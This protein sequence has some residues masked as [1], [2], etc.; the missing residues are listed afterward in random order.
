MKSPK[1]LYSDFLNGRCLWF[2]NSYSSSENL[3]RFSLLVRDVCDIMIL[4]GSILPFVN[5]MYSGRFS[6]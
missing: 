2:E 6:Y 4:F 3:L 1:F 5:S